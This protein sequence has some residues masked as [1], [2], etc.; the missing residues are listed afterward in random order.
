MQDNIVQKEFDPFFNTTPVAAGFTDV[1][2]YWGYYFIFGPIC[3][4]SI[5]L[6]H[7]GGAS[8]R[9]P[10]GSAMQ[11]PVP[12]SMRGATYLL[13]DHKCFPATER[14]HPN[15]VQ[16]WFY[17]QPTTIVA[18]GGHTGAGAS[19]DTNVSGWYFRE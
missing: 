13:E 17:I 8:V 14:Q 1:G 19:D 15:V 12:A 11:I 7:S 3:Y 5:T 4:F 2:N 18:A 16:D 9:W 6:I 10:A